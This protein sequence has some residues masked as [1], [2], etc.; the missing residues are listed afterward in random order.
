MKLLL[1]FAA[2]AIVAIPTPAFADLV[3]NYDANNRPTSVIDL[4][5]SGFGIFNLTVDYSGNSF[6]TQFGTATPPLPLPPSLGWGDASL[7]LATAEALRDAMNADAQPNVV[8]N[9]DIWFP[10]SATTTGFSAIDLFGLTGS[11]WNSATVNPGRNNA[12]GSVGWA[13]IQAI[14]E[15]SA[16]VC[17][18]VA[19]I[20]I[21][22]WNRHKPS[23]HAQD[24]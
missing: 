1:T 16:F 21:S 6:N 8:V 3:I 17:I 14:P 15:P 10:Y 22:V 12:G 23:D 7:S 20:G 24:G 11:P 4:P 2:F 18:S 9:T 19:A 5:V 13:N